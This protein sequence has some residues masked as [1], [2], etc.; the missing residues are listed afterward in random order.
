MNQNNNLIDQNKDWKFT[1]EIDS[2]S[3]LFNY[4][5]KYSASFKNLNNYNIRGIEK[6][7]QEESKDSYNDGNF[8]LSLTVP[9]GKNEIIYEDNPILINF[10]EDRKNPVGTSY[11]ALV[12]QYLLISS[13]LSLDHLSSF[14][15][16]ART[17]CSPIKDKK[18]I[19]RTL[20]NNSWSM[21]S[22]LPKRD[23]NTL[24]LNDNQKCLLKDIKN[25]LKEEDEYI[26]YGQPYK[27]NFLLHGPPGTGKTSIIYTIAS[28]LNMD[29]SVVSFGPKLDDVGLLQAVSN[30]P[31]N[32]I[33]LLEDIDALFINRK[34]SG[35][36]N[37]MVSFSCI[38]NILDGMGR[39][40]KMITFMTTNHLD[41]LDPALI[42]PG[43]IDKSLLFD[44]ASIEQI[45]SMFKHFF[46]EELINEN[47]I[48]KLQK[49][50]VTTAIL[51]TFLFKNRKLDKIND[52]LEEL[53]EMCK[54]KKDE[55]PEHMYI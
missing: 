32:S 29:I 5:L 50:K 47:V 37:S 44:Y 2:N 34:N 23:F 55:S 38:L 54:Q 45:N 17:Y 27:L 40:H 16:K 20:K 53:Y 12:I 15:L 49:L 1:M 4:I 18:I 11:S 9:F 10:S 48:K 6:Y 28:E 43:R 25:F 24:F 42:R 26:K 35:E 7:D 22:K 39:K 31:E 36:S 3:S 8:N 52:V 33:L 30:L 51:Q 46:P 13:N 41:R 14:T 19:C 21:L